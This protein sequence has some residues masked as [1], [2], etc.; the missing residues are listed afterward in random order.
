VSS[1]LAHTPARV[2][3]QVLIDLG[4]AT[5]PEATTPGPWPVYAG[6]EPDEPDDAL[7]VR[8]TAGRDLG[9]SGPDST[10][11]ELYG[12]QVRVRSA[13]EQEG[14]L[15]A[16]AIALALDIVYRRA[17]AVGDSTYMLQHAARTG[18]PLPLGTDSPQTERWLCTLNFLL[19]LSMT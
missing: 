10:R 13:V 3:A 8:T 4:L 5:N 15:K 17:V 12:V 19:S 14:Y 2:L 6:K 16:Q 9:R 7:T 1:V 18:P 11:V